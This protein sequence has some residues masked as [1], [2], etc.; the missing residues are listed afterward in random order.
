MGKQSVKRGESKVEDNES[1]TDSQTHSANTDYLESINKNIKIILKRMD[2]QDKKLDDLRLDISKYKEEL[3]EF[4]RAT[5]ENME[6]IIKRTKDVEDSQTLINNNFEDN[7]KTCTNIL[8]Q[9]TQTEKDLVHFHHQ[10]TELQVQLEKEMTDRI[11]LAQYGRRNMVEISGIPRT[12]DENTTELIT[13]MAKLADIVDFDPLQIDVAH[14]VSIREN[15]P[16]IALF[17]CRNERESF[18]AQR[19]KLQYLHVRQFDEKDEQQKYATKKEQTTRS[20]ATKIYLNE[21]LTPE[22][23]KLLADVRDKIKKLKIDKSIQ[24]KYV[25]THHREI[26]VRKDDADKM[27]KINNAS[28]INKIK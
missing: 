28:D 17:H 15:A 2:A 26:R 27:M 25:W 3:Q 21:S 4:K 1:T 11:N 18:Y 12:E 5:H 13:K 23:S 6:A 10:V 24:Y 9:H 8:K 16:I 7:K 19:S 14:R 22:R 20:P